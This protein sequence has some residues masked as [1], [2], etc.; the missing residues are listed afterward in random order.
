[1]KKS[2][3]ASEM[4]ETDILI[5]YF[6]IAYER[7][8]WNYDKNIKKG[9]SN[10]WILV[11]HK[12]NTSFMASIRTQPFR[13][14]SVFYSFNIFSKNSNKHTQSHLGGN[15]TDADGIRLAGEHKGKRGK[16]MNRTKKKNRGTVCLL[17]CLLLAA[18]TIIA[19]AAEPGTDKGTG[20]SENREHALKWLENG[21]DSGGE[22]EQDAPINAA[23][24][25]LVLL[26]EENATAQSTWLRERAAAIT[27]P[28]T[29]T[30]AR[31]IQAGETGAGTLSD[32][33][34]R[35]NDDGG[36]GLDETYTSDVFDT[37]LALRALLTARNSRT[38]G[39]GVSG[40]GADAVPD[41]AA[42]K[43][44]AYLMGRQ[45]E[46]GGFA[47]TPYMPSDP[48]LS[49][50][51]GITL[52]ETGL[53]D[54]KTLERMDDYCV[55]Q[56]RAVFSEEDCREYMKLARCLY[57][58]GLMEEP[59]KTERKLEELPESDGSIH[60]SMED[61]VQYIR[62]LGEIMAYHAPKL[63]ICG[64]ET[65]ADSY[66]LET[67]KEQKVSLQ[68]GITYKTNK[69]LTVKI[70][71]SLKENGEIIQ[72]Q[73]EDCTLMPKGRYEETKTTAVTDFT[74]TAGKD[75]A[76][77]ILVELAWTDGN[78]ETKTWK[79]AP[80][81]FTLHESR[82]K[83][84][85]LEQ[86]TSD[87]KEYT[88]TLSWNDIS[89]GDMR[90]RY[91]ILEQKAQGEWN[92]TTAWDG[93]EKVKVL[94]IYPCAAAENYLKEWMEGAL[95]ESEEA[96]GKGLFEIDAILLD[97][98]NRDPDSYLKDAAGNYRYDVLMFG[99]YDSN[100]YKDLSEKGYLAARAFADAGGGILFGHDTV[101][102]S[103]GARHPW[104]AKFADA[105]GVKLKGSYTKVPCNRV[106]VVKKGILTEYPW[107]LSGTLEIPE[108]HSQ[109][110]YTGGTMP[111]EVW[112]EFTKYSETDGETGATDKAY[113]FHRGGLAM[114]QTGHSNGQATDDERKVLAN[115]LF[116]LKQATDR[117]TVKPAAF[118]DEAPPQAPE[119]TVSGNEARITARD[120]GT[121]YAYRVQAV[122]VTA[123]GKEEKTIKESNEIHTEAVSGIC[124]FVITVSDSPEEEVPADGADNGSPAGGATG[125]DGADPADNTT[126]PIVEAEDGTVVYSL[127][128]L[129]PGK[130][131]YL[132]AY[133][134]DN[135]GNAGEK[136][137][138]SFTPEP[139]KTE[140]V[141][142]KDEEKQAYMNL[143]YALFSTEGE[144]TLSCSTAD[145]QGD[146]YAA[147]AFRFQG[148]TLLLDGTAKSPGQVSIAR[149]NTDEAATQEGAGETAL[150]DYLPEI[151]ESME[152][153]ETWEEIA[154]Y[155][156]TE[157]TVP[158]RCE[159]TTG[160]W[161]NDVA[162]AAD[163]VSEGSI[164]L[165]SN[166]ISC[167]TAEK[168]VL[169]SV[170][171][172]ITVQATAIAGSG[173]IYAPNGTVTINVSDFDYRGTII[174]REIRIQVSNYRHAAEN[175][176]DDQQG[177][178]K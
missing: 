32:L 146:I 100:D 89:D 94:N 102:L 117:T 150:P 134:V 29:D 72:K 107:K 175:T 114:I 124:G 43:A 81:T 73:E 10:F 66:V 70:S 76:Y 177:E 137:V 123:D 8:R 4:D 90:Y 87:G 69:E 156:S 1:M 27:D 159:K 154:S 57:M 132:H 50:D 109:A 128:G 174:A 171:G 25:A 35:Q 78:G 163:L 105:L 160:A 164:S 167:G 48:E 83:E 108:S 64:M 149:G 138:R 26:G 115:T 120:G 155:N 91:R 30:L 21:Q 3:V 38:G 54:E 12:T 75:A 133:A 172:N 59:E 88:A 121:D 86:T 56:Y 65:E 99:S 74:I 80:L 37:M 68:T 101:T 173:L 168:T 97:A 126:A 140:D 2:M 135:A 28:D 51:V 18:N 39:S 158:T 151:L 142:G 23:C 42:R 130:T 106:R 139:E 24:D 98:Y 125:T 41:G 148:S 71:Y 11:Y 19:A 17:L 61:T 161:C 103:G 46:D 162:I 77:E 165:N 84:I 33:I 113:L 157:I 36:F 58:R 111:A 104:F 153:A 79:E 129:E 9:L 178:Q 93:E 136:S 16:N 116:Y 152:T 131:Y 22:W 53:A 49:A 176:K 82:Q 62:L 6:F 122:P 127:G 34:R 60:G 141:E 67:D 15:Q 110:Q 166:R 14:A 143:P 44:A 170:N 45:N 5:P 20:L 40:N 13:D 119:I 169:C 118:R 92:T 55:R 145:I 85:L 47:Y 147:Q 95:D 7:M 52:I 144:T 112:M 63:T 31:L 96:A